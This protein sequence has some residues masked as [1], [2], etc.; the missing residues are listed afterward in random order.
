MAANPAT[1]HEPFVIRRVAVLAFLIAL[2]LANAFTARAR[3]Q[4]LVVLG[5][6]LVAGLGL[7]PGEAFPEK[8]AA[9]LAERGRQ[10]RVI[11]A[12][13]SGDT[14]AGGL[15]RLD[16]AVPPE[17]TAVIVELGANDALRGLDPE[18]T[19]QNLDAIVSRLRGRGLQVLVAGMLAPPNLG[20]DY[21]QAFGTIYPE[22]AARH[23]ATLFPFFLEGVAAQANLNQE[24]GI[25][26]TAQG[27]DVIVAN[28]LPYVEA[29]LDGAGG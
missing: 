2:T 26:P 10:I 19:R 27:I 5:D 13:V 9:A 25:H 22:I 11:N 16:W 18:A 21:G 15:E 17:A 12:G 3:E 4:V 8:L 23:S 7:K 1:A 14:S 6:S 29:L 24:D 28:I 20:R